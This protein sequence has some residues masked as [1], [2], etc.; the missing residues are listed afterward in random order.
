MDSIEFVS[1]GAVRSVGAPVLS[2][3]ANHKSTR[4][5]GIRAFLSGTTA[6]CHSYNTPH[7]HFDASLQLGRHQFAAQPSVAGAGLTRHSLHSYTRKRRW[8]LLVT[9]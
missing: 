1:S 8:A 3:G 4:A 2:G 9:L 5:G 6:E 7:L